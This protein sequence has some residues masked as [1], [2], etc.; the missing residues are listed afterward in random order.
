MIQNTYYV[1]IF[2]IIC[3]SFMICVMDVIKNTNPKLLGYFGFVSA[4]FFLF[5]LFQYLYVHERVQSQSSSFLRHSCLGY[6]VLFVL[7]LFFLVAIEY[8]QWNVYSILASFVIL[9]LLIWSIYLKY[10]RFLF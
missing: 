10:C 9:N 4:S 2:S 3:L 1:F 5:Q 8:T 6:F 7:S